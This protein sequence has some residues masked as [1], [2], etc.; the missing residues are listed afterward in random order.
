MTQHFGATHDEW[1]HFADVLG[2]TADLLP[3]VSNP[4]AT[5]SPE[6]RMKSIG[7]TPSRYNSSRHVSG[8]AQWTQHKSTPAEVGAWM[9]EPDYGI[10]IQTR[11]V[12]AIDVDIDDN[13]AK[14]VNDE[15]S[16]F[17]HTVLPARV[18]DNA[19]KFLLVFQMPGEH[20]KRVIRTDHGIIEFL[21]NGQQF[22]AAGTHTSGARYHWRTG[23]PDSVPSLTVEQFDKLWARLVECFAA[24]GTESTT[25]AS[26]VKQVVLSEAIKNDPVAVSLIDSGVARSTERDGRIH[27]VCPF[28]AEHT[29]D[30]DESATTYFPAHTG[31]FKWGHFQCL[32]AHCAD[33]PDSAF[34]DALGIS[35]STDDFDILTETEGDEGA[36]PA[37][38]KWTFEHCSTSINTP[39]PTWIIKRVLPQAGLAVT[40]GDSGSGKTFLA[41]DMSVS[42]ALGEQWRG[43]RVKQGTVAYVAAEDANGV[44]M[45]IKAIAQQRGINLADVPLYILPESPNFM[46]GED[47]ADVLKAVRA[48]PSKPSVIFVDTWAQVTPGANENSGEDM[49]KALGYCKQLHKATKALIVLIH[50]SGKDS[51]KGARGWSGLRAAADCE[52]EVSRCDDDREAQI[53]KQKNATDGARFGFRLL[54]VVVGE[55]EDGE[56]I[57]SCVLEHTAPRAE[58][59]REVKSK[60][61]QDVK[62]WFLALLNDGDKV[63]VTDL[64][65]HAKTERVGQ[66]NTAQ[67][68]NRGIDALISGGFFERDGPYLQN[69][70]G[71]NLV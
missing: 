60:P 25:A 51:S 3:V 41:L 61:A 15:I 55:D 35:V 9:R 23:L 8:I 40:Y 46:K 43:N 4:E 33:R 27:I 11:T 13:I 68:V 19:Q 2:L 44:R 24:A 47:V 32:H 12:R 53:T 26:P 17:L 30:S 16:K 28:A 66:R 21:A 71:E 57:V 34:L 62:R 29:T 65:E 42:I 18:R 69:F 67:H 10:C 20:T 64:I 50:H 70:A 59:A 31:G 5:I 54:P 6:S 7:K 49:G 1:V 48:M 37:D 22:I 56:D 14:E 58:K 52:I 45:R 36:P 38:L 39:P 63:A